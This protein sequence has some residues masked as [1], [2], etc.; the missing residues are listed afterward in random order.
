MGPVEIIL[1]LAVI[2]LIF[3]AKKLPE[4]GKGVGQGLREFK[5]GTKDEAASVN[6]TQ[7]A[8]PLTDRSASQPVQGAQTVISTRPDDRR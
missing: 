2:L 5:A 1:I 8:A 4:L 6:Q 3:G 7:P